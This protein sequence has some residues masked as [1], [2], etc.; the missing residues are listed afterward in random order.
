VDLRT[1]LLLR[2]VPQQKKMLFKMYLSLPFAQIEANEGLS[3]NIAPGHIVYVG[4]G[5]GHAHTHPQLIFQ[6]SGG[7][8]ANSKRHLYRGVYLPR[9]DRVR[10][11]AKLHEDVR[12]GSLMHEMTSEDTEGGEFSCIEYNS[13]SGLLS[14]A[15]AERYVKSVLYMLVVLVMYLPVPIII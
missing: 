12:F 7:G 2:V 1:L 13:G 5:G 3:A 14:T 10:A 8:G 15:I 6:G 4:H 9:Q 11:T